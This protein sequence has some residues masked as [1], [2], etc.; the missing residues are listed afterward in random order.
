MGQRSSR[1]FLMAELVACAVCHQSGLLGFVSTGSRIRCGSGKP[2][3]G[4]GGSSRMSGNFEI[5]GFLV[6]CICFLHFM[7]EL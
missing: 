7:K 2:R 6:C 5:V 4:G 1:S 3:F